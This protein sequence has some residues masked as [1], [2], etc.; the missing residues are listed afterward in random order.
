MDKEKLILVKLWEG[1]K[2]FWALL[3][4]TFGELIMVIKRFLKKVGLS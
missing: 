4:I 3:E 1:K 2:L